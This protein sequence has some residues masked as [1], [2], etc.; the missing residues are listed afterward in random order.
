[1]KHLK[2]FEEYSEKS[3]W[4]K[5]MDYLTKQDFDLYDGE[6]VLHQK[7]IEIS[8]SSYSPDEKAD[9]IASYLDEKWGLYDGYQYVVDFLI[10]LFSK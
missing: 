8:D 4:N 10:H 3:D 1:M 6:D 5:F 7:F 9:E 2:L